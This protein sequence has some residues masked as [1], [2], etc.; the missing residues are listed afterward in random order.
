M[1]QPL[2]KA[3][4]NLVQ[5]I[6]DKSVEFYDERLISFVVFGSVGRRVMRPDSD[7]DFIPTEEYE[8]GD[9]PRAIEDAR[10]VC[11]AAAKVIPL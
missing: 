4:E 11:V 5:A 8:P 6:R 3:F 9:A 10:F 1:M 2:A 7:I